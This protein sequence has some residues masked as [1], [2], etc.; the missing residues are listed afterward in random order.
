MN[1]TEGV[2]AELLV[3]SAV[4]RTTQLEEIGYKISESTNLLR[5]GV[6][7]ICHLVQF[8][9]EYLDVNLNKALLSPSFVKYFAQYLIRSFLDGIILMRQNFWRRTQ[10]EHGLGVFG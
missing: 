10:F 3:V 7:L 4:P 6:G 8:L 9:V 1:S 5:S 2:R